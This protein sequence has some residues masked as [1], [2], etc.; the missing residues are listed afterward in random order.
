MD[1]HRRGVWHRDIKPEN[2]LV[3]ADGLPRLADFG[4]AHLSPR[5]HA[6]PT[7]R[8]SLSTTLGTGS[9][10]YLAP[11]CLPLPRNQ[12]TAYDC[13]K[14]DVWSLAILVVNCVAAQCVWEVADEERDE[15][16]RGFVNCGSKAIWLRRHVGMGRRAAEWVVKALEGKE[17]RVGVEEWLEELEEGV[18]AGGWRW[19]D[20]AGQEDS[21]GEWGSARTSR[22]SVP[23]HASPGPTTPPRHRTPV[24]QSITPRS[25]VTARSW[26]KAHGLSG[27]SWA[28]AA[29]DDGTDSDGEGEG[30]GFWNH[31]PVFGSGG[32]EEEEEAEVGG[33]RGD[34][35]G[36]GGAQ[37]R[38]TSV[39][40][41]FAFDVAD[42]E[43]FELARSG[44]GAGAAYGANV[45][46]ETEVDSATGYY[47]PL[48]DG[49][50][51]VRRVGRAGRGVVEGDADAVVGNRDG[52]EDGVPAEG[53]EEAQ[54]EAKKKKKKKRAKSG[55]RA[56][57]GGGDAGS[58]KEGGLGGVADEGETEHAMDHQAPGVDK[59]LETKEERKARR[60]AEKDMVAAGAVHSVVV[61]GVAVAEGKG[62]VGR[63]DAVSVSAAEGVPVDK[64]V[65]KKKK[66]K[67]KGSTA[68]E[69]V[70]GTGLA[71]VVVSSVTAAGEAVPVKSGGET[72]AKTK[73]AK[74]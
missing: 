1:I 73:S 10:R 12:G 52:K 51:V 70:Q 61:D 36:M 69:A 37:G 40:D 11:E 16:Y 67:R 65:K 14:A 25:Y 7:P 4:L 60:K 53:A 29:S 13:G 33:G 31:V 68:E 17:T 27:V 3:G 24:A 38:R 62:N 19:R 5:H 47:V 74:V 35:G 39:A 21:D 9:V 48:R 54:Q 23:H 50:G 66:H 22:T 30:N 64:E 20:I 71:A 34:A 45:H 32:E 46:G 15:G 2:V 63:G 43:E 58:E 26:T 72:P 59:K 56:G 6:R 57:G 42:E 55:S 8:D 41:V 49:P 44:G 18:R 28:D